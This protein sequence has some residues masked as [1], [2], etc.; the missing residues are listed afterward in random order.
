M[1]LW[2]RVLTCVCVF[3]QLT[4][5]QK[6]ETNLFDQVDDFKWLKATASPNWSVLP[7][8]ETVPED[9]WLKTLVGGPGVAIEETLRKLGA[10]KRA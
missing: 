6:G 9:V 4:D 3:R 7:E 5:K 1:W 8:T 10:C 2:K